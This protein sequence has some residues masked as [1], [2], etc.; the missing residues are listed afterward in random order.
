MW[1]PWDFDRNDH[2]ILD[3]KSKYSGQYWPVQIIDIH[4]SLTRCNRFLNVQFI[5]ELVGIRPPLWEMYYDLIFNTWLAIACK[6]NKSADKIIRIITSESSF[7]HRGL[8]AIN[9]FSIPQSR[10]LSLII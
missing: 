9:C 6:N 10:D 2:S 3:L 1:P 8:R 4:I 5:T 7:T